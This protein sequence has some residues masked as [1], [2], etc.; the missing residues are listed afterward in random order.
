M[1]AGYSIVRFGRDRHRIATDGGGLINL[2][3][4]N[5][6]TAGDQRR[7][8]LGWTLGDTSSSPLRPGFIVG[9]TL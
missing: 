6:Y 9:G 2:Y 3:V 4:C 5:V 8:D 7:C 1:P